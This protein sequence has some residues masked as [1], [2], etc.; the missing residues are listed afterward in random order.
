MKNLNDFGLSRDVENEL[1]I[2]GRNG[3]HGNGMFNFM[4]CE[5]G[6]T[7]RVICS[8]GGGWDHVSVSRVD[9]VPTYRE[10]EQVAKIIFQPDEYAVQY[11]V[12]ASEHVNFHKYCL[13]WWRPTRELLPH[14]PTMMVGPK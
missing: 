5:D 14:P 4:S 8:D 2:Y 10:M 9:R 3:D 11:H 7:L 12:P 1:K 13:H 6:K